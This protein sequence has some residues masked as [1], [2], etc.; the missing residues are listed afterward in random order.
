MIYIVKKIKQQKN[1]NKKHLSV[2][3]ACLNDLKL[4]LET[5]KQQQESVISSSATHNIFMLSV[6]TN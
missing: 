2:H 6:K 1:P 3:V 5:K 4:V